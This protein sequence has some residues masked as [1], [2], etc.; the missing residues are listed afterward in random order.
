MFSSTLELKI[1]PITLETNEL[2]FLFN[3]QPALL[4]NRHP[5]NLIVKI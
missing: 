4:F 1:N 2:S 5:L 3:K